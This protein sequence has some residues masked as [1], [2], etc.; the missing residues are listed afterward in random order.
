MRQIALF[1]DTPAL[2][3]SALIFGRKMGYDRLKIDYTRLRAGIA[4][5]LQG[6]VVRSVA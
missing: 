6:V 4:A 2:W 3:D 1:I 5:A